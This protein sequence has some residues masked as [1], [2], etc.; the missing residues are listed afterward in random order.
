[1]VSICHASLYHWQ[2]R[3]DCTS[4][5]LSIGYW[6]LSRVYAVLGQA[7]N[8]RE[9]AKFCSDFSKDEGAF[10]LGY[11]Y[12]A[13]ARAEFLAGNDRAGEHFLEQARIQLTN[14][15]DVTERE[16]LAR[17]L[18]TMKSTTK[19]DR[20][21]LTRFELDAVRNA[22]VAE[23]YCAFQN[24]TREGGVSWSESVALDDYG[25]PDVCE[26][27]RLGD[28][29]ANWG[30][31]VDDERWVPDCGSGGFNFLDANGFRYYL[32]P[33]MVR[34]LRSSQDEGI[35]LKLA[36]LQNRP[37]QFSVLDQRQ[38]RCVARFLLYMARRSDEPYL[39]CNDK[40][41]WLATLNA[42]WSEY[43]NNESSSRIE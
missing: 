13:L 39:A 33:A 38:R 15:T 28:T 6:Q 35:R 22:I 12:E 5:N 29:D 18:E 43:L 19:P 21:L 2:Q 16:L 17:D 14:V 42:G 37:E 11:A 1:M 10:L 24:V 32:P 4:R 23:I 30:E 9:S 41:E 34:S 7:D 31:L 8:A 36:A 3:P 26:A 20:S 40:N 25:G 27:A